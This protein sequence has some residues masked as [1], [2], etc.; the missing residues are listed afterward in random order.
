MQTF[1]SRKFYEPHLKL[2][3]QHSVL[4]FHNHCVR[5]NINRKQIETKHPAILA[6]G[7]YFDFTILQFHQNTFVFR[8]HLLTLQDPPPRFSFHHFVLRIC[9]FP[10]SCNFKTAPLMAVRYGESTKFIQPQFDK[11]VQLFHCKAVLCSFLQDS[12]FFR[13]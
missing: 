3:G 8:K 1:L 6:T 7:D 13:S 11:L 2:F 5:S 4:F 10:S 9:N 12:V